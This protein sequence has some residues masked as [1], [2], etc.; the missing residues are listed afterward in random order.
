MSNIR[1]YFSEENR[2]NTLLK[3]A[4]LFWLIAKLMSWRIWTTYRLY[5][6]AP[7]FND[8]SNVSPV[9]H[10]ILFT[11]SILL[12]TSLLFKQNRFLPAGLLITEILSCL[13][14]QTRLQPWE[15]QYIFVAFVFLINFN[16]QGYII[17]ALAFIMASTYFYSGCSKFNS[18]FLQE[19]WTKSILHS[20]LKISMASTRIRFVYFSGYL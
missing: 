18:G 16:K 14:D 5:P 1:K 4:C 13:L 17:P 3:V 12:I 2:S 7:V 11:I 6:T 15:Y 20:F 10:L 8:L 19:I 9:I